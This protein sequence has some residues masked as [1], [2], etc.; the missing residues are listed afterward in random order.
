MVDKRFTA[1]LGHKSPQR[2]SFLDFKK[3]LIVISV[4]L[5]IEPKIG[6]TVL[7]QQE[8][9]RCTNLIEE[10]GQHLEVRKSFWY[11]EAFNSF[12]CIAAECE[13]FLDASRV[14]LQN[15]DWLF[16]VVNCT[17]TS[18]DELTL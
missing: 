8:F 16:A 13:H 17:D 1:I 9:F 4:A 14:F 10:L 15:F 7:T 6:R 3:V 11:L 12:V 18:V 5:I 2:L